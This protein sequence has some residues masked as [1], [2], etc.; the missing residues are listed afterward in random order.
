MPGWLRASVAAVW[1]GPTR[2]AAACPDCAPIR[3]ARAA[4]ADDPAFWTYVLLT[5]LPFVFVVA[6]AAAA[7]RLGRPAREV[8]S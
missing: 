1:L 6:I 2:L 3:A 8:R 4:I 7:H 5:A